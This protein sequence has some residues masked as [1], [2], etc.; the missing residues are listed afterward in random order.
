[1]ECGGKL[2]TAPLLCSFDQ[3]V[4]GECEVTS[5]PAT[6]RR[7]YDGRT[8]PGHLSAAIILAELPNLERLRDARLLAAHSGVTPR[9]K[10]S[11]T[12]LLGICFGREAP[13]TAFGE[14][15]RAVKRGLALYRCDEHF[16]IL[17]I[18]LMPE[19]RGRGIGTTLLRQIFE[20]AGLLPVRLFAFKGGRAIELYH[21]PGFPDVK[22]DPLHIELVWR[23]EP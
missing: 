23:A 13:E 18:A 17:D 2:N 12:R 10:Q 14:D 6:R 15:R 19:F 9:H 8:D 11:G 16:E 5:P 1:M 22:V 20:E 3:L 4:R 21:R 7:C